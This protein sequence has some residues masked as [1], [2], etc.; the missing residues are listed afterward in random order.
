MAGTRHRHRQF[1]SAVSGQIRSTHA[2]FNVFIGN[3]EF[4]RHNRSA[5]MA[6]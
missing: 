1:N 4:Q 5:I 2:L 6:A 3:N